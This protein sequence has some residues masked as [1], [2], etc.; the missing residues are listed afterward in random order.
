MNGLIYVWLQSCYMHG[1]SLYECC[2]IILLYT[3]I[4]IIIIITI[5]LEFNIGSQNNLDIFFKN[6]FNLFLL[7]SF[8][9][10]NCSIHSIA[11]SVKPIMP[12]L[13]HIY[14]L[15]F[16]L[17]HLHN[18]FDDPNNA[19]HAAISLYKSISWYISSFE[20]FRFISVLWVLA[21]NGTFWH[22]DFMFL[23]FTL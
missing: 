17:G 7:C 1:M 6:L 18:I 9:S 19:F 10:K 13:L 3:P 14:S 22:I 16:H 23:C 12:S 20:K 5:T 21:D 11:F 8:N 15:Q 2:I 4:I